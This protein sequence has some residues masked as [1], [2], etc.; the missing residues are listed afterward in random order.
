LQAVALH[1]VSQGIPAD[2][3]QFGCLADISGT[4]RQS[5]LDVLAFH[6]IQ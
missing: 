6:G 5:P 3:E 4:L 2:A 1:A